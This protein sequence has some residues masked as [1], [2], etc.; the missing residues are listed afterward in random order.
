MQEACA[1][2]LH[3][4]IQYNTQFTADIHMFIILYL[5]SCNVTYVMEEKSNTDIVH[6]LG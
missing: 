2:K 1:F 4:T 5:V 3:N 6:N